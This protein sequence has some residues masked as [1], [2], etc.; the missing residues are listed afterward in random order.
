MVFFGF[1]KG[2]LNG[3]FSPAVYPFAVVRLRKRRNGIQC[4]LPYM[5]FHHPSG[6]A[7]SKAFFSSRTLL[8]FFPVAVVLPVSFP[9]GGFSIEHLLFGAD[10]H[11]KFRIVSEAIFPIM[12]PGVCMPPVANY[13]PYAFLFQ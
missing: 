4:I 3:L 8:A 10:V 2:A 12:L 11:V 7:C 1:R 9:G 6:C 5:S 13:S